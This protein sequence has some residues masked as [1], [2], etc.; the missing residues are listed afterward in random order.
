MEIIALIQHGQIHNQ[1]EKLCVVIENVF[2]FQAFYF[3]FQTWSLYYPQCN[4]I[5]DSSVGASSV[6]I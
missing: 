4:L 6:L 3:L 2:L 1:L 5:A